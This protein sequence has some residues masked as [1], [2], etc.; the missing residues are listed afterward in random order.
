L[1]IE[2]QDYVKIKILIGEGLGIQYQDLDIYSMERRI[3]SVMNFLGGLYCIM[4][5][6]DMIGM[7]MGMSKSMGI[8]IYFGINEA[9]P[10]KTQS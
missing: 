7:I 3:R 6:L 4:I 9:W 5:C 1:R 8:I 2:G 10:Q